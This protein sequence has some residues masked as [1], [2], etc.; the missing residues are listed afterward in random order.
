MP[1]SVF[2]VSQVPIA[3][4]I[5]GLQVGGA[6]GAL[7]ELATRLDRRR[8]KPVVYSLL[9][10]PPAEQSALVQKLAAAEVRIEFLN[11]RGWWSLPRVVGRLW[12]C[13][14]RERPTLVQG[15]LFHANLVAALAAWLAGVPA[16]VTG[17]R[18]AEPR[19]WHLRLARWTDWMVQRHVCV[20]RA[21]A[22]YA[23]S[24]GG[25]PSEKLVVI[26]NGVDAERFINARPADLQ[27]FGIRPGWRVVTF[28]GRLAPQKGLDLLIQQA[29]SLFSQV[30]EVD[31]LLVGHG[32]ARATLERQVRALNLSDRIHFAGWQAD[33]P[34][35]LAASEV[36]VLPSRWEGMPNVVLEAMAAG[37]PV[38]AAS[39]EGISELLGPGADAQSAPPEDAL[40]FRELVLFLLK[41][42]HQAALLGEQNRL[43][44]TREFCIQKM[45]ERYESLYTS[46]LQPAVFAPV[47]EDF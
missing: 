10:A 12:R 6:E 30:P 9:P 29:A 15:F 3:F 40:A 44:A 37:K 34:E 41:A 8:F 21:V 13:F 22:D 14:S 47:H 25:L 16:V 18:V 36:V 46:L 1:V 5:T 20:S 43:R 27:S 45:I 11:A 42:P 31:L 17:I 35:I 32:P 19:R 4:V 33:I 24:S 28:I 39:V 2:D 38:A 26:P 7:V 23:V